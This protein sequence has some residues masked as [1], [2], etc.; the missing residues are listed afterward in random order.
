MESTAAEVIIATIPIVGIAIGGTVAFFSLL[1]HHRERTLQIKT[2]RYERRTFDLG[3]WS[4]LVGLLLTSV[5]G[6]LTLFFAVM[7]AMNPAAYPSLLGGL[8]PLA[9][10]TSLLVFHRLARPRGE[11]SS[12]NPNPGPADE[13]QP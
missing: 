6:V 9:V 12:P 4:L 2:G 8:I 5:G 10:G 3:A 7:T 1:W 11:S 13:K